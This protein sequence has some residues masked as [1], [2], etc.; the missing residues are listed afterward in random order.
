MMDRQLFISQL[1]RHEGFRDR[2]YLDSE[3]VPTIGYGHALIVGSKIP[4][5][6][7]D[8]IFNHDVAVSIG[9]YESLGLKISNPARKFALINMIFN[10]GLTAFLG[11]T[12]MVRAI[13]YDDWDLV[14]NEALDSKWAKQ[15]GQRAVEIAEMLRT[16]EYNEKYSSW[17]HADRVHGDGGT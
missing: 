7:C 8:I 13:E 6:A 5:E 11:F 17:P 9:E 10:I 16:G 1:K 12:K 15:V 14:S 4:K 2:V 3:G